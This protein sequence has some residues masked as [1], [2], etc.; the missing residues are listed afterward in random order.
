MIF[1]KCPK[2]DLENPETAKFCNECGAKRGA[3]ESLPM[4]QQ[5][6]AR[7]PEAKPELS[8]APEAPEAESGRP[9]PDEADVTF[10]EFPCEGPSPQQPFGARFKVIEELGTGTLGKVYKVFDKAMEMDQALK[11]VKPEISQKA[12]AFEGLAR[13]LKVERGIV[14]KNIARIFELN[15]LKGTPFITM[16]YVSGRDLR[17]ILKEKKRLP[18]REAI[19]IAK[20]LF[21]GLAHA[22]ELG[23]LHLDLRPENIMIDK[24][25]TVKIMDLGIARLFRAKGII[26]PVAGMP[27]NMSP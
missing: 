23:A 11:A 27:Q 9:S 20:Q 17:S 19:S 5:G 2:C 1:K 7:A 13:E 22:H 3:A 15:V 25:G 8:A 6:P 21:G 24:E 26:R 18:V 4:P 12:E 10:E 14:H 16:E